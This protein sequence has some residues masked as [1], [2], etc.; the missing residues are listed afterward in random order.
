M[1]VGSAS[2]LSFPQAVIGDAEVI[3]DFRV[4]GIAQVKRLEK[5]LSLF[6]A[7]KARGKA[8]GGFS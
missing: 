4:G 2:M 5:L 3:G 8:S 6:I 7:K 1:L